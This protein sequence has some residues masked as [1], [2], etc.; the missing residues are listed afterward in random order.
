MLA[1][2]ARLRTRSLLSITAAVLPARTLEATATH[3]R[4]LLPKLVTTMAR[5]TTTASPVRR[6]STR[7][8]SSAKKEIDAEQPAASPSAPNKSKRKAADPT[9]AAD[10]KQSGTDATAEASAAAAAAPTKKPR[11]KAVADSDSP[12]A[13]KSEDT[14]A[15]PGLPKNTEMP[16]TL[17]YARQQLR[18]ACESLRGTSPASSRANPRA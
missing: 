9:S 15:D 3:H 5:A 12:S 14:L 1:L 4:H 17:S 10:P 18:K 6:A 2:A 11:K 16:A 8:S 13:P 7:T